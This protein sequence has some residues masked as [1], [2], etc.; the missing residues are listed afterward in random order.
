MS[1]AAQL[2]LASS[3]CWIWQ[4]TLLEP[5][6]LAST[7]AGGGGGSRLSQFPLLSP[8]P[9][10]GWLYI[11]FFGSAGSQTLFFSLSCPLPV[12][13]NSSD[14]PLLFSA[15][16]VP[17]VFPEGQKGGTRCER[18]G[19]SRCSLSW[20]MIPVKTAAE[21]P[22][23]LPIPESTLLVSPFGTLSTTRGSCGP[24]D[25]PSASLLPHTSCCLHPHLGQRCPSLLL[26]QE[27]PCQPPLGDGFNFSHLGPSL[28]SHRSFRAALLS[29][30]L[31]C[32]SMPPSISHLTHTC[33]LQ[34]SCQLPVLKQ[35]MRLSV[36]VWPLTPFLFR[37]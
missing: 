14:P 32:Y 12:S 19:P 18:I 33:L 30:S 5:Y 26:R 10:G 31:S 20:K 7:V 23:S 34:F 36:S 6:G 11:G 29:L 37:G 9:L 13:Q 25:L 2:C 28:G 3:S 24:A 1:G 22:A 8:A 4:T 35:D 15:S 27:L 17:S 16:S 21:A